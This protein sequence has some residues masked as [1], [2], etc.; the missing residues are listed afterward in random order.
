MAT[1]SWPPR[2]RKL[3]GLDA[4]IKAHGLPRAMRRSSA[5]CPISTLLHVRL[6]SGLQMQAQADVR[7]PDHFTREPYPRGRAAD[8]PNVETERLRFCFGVACA[9]EYRS[10]NARSAV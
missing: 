7:P 2:L 5:G 3:G 1:L 8:L 4:K 10:L 9:D 6:T